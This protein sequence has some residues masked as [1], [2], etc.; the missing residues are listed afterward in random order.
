MVGLY[1]FSPFWGTVYL[2]LLP[3]PRVWTDNAFADIWSSGC[4]E[5]G[6]FYD[7]FLFEF[8]ARCP[9]TS[10][11]AQPMR[12]FFCISR[13]KCWLCV[14]VI[15]NIFFVSW[16]P[17]EI[18]NW[19]CCMK[20]TRFNL[21]FLSNLQDMN[22]PSNFVSGSITGCPSNSTYNKPPFLP[23]KRFISCL[24]VSLV[25]LIIYIVP[26]AKEAY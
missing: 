21:W 19:T 7:D 6:I 10:P 9:W 4:L 18:W 15:R 14:K 13:F 16:K 5:A 3:F 1:T 11:Q 8:F 26:N 17:L 22:E 24:S 2:H 23:G 12:N 20:L 25:L